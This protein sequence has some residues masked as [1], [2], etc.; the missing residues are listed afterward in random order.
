MGINLFV[1]G[2]PAPMV[3][4][5]K[6]PRIVS[7]PKD[8]HEVASAIDSILKTIWA[9]EWPGLRHRRNRQTYILSFHVASPPDFKI[10]T[11]PAWL[12]VFIAILAGYRQI[13]ENVAEIGGDLGSILRGIHGL[14]DRQLQLLEIAVR[15]SLDRL[16]AQGEQ[17]SLKTAEKMR[18][19][20]Q[21]LL[22][23]SNEAPEIKILDVDK[24]RLW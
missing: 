22:G 23:E 6:L 10:F 9:K 16:L 24:D 13:K 5:I 20:R 7:T 4:S 14:S 19:T 2:N 17:A 8:L 3:I 11:D 1:E 18:R 21:R 15:L 12:A